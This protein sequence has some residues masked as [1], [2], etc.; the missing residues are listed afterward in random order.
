[1]GL[2][3]YAVFTANKSCAMIFL[4]TYKRTFMRNLNNVETFILVVETNSFTRAAKVRGISRAAASKQVRQLEDELGVALLMRSTREIVVTAEGQIVYEECRRIMENVT[5]VEAIL[6]GLKDEPSGLLSV[7]SGP[8]FANKYIIPYLAEFIEHYPK[9]HL[10]LD[11]RHLM[12]NMMEEKVDV[13]VGVYG[14]APP[15]AIQRS[16]IQTRR[17]MCASPTYLKKIGRPKKPADLLKH[18]LIIHPVHPNDSSIILK[19]G[20]QLNHM[21][22]VT[23]NDQLAIK[24][25]ALN[26]MGVAYIQRHVVEQEL[27]DGSLV[28]V[29]QDY[30]EKKDSISI[31]LYYLQRRHLHSKIRV[32]IDFVINNIERRG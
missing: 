27:Q 18:S 2:Y 32:F 17:I 8:V 22:T 30:M 25:C 20:K 24:R 26:D 11:L 29:L 7:V 1:M 10:K 28:E 31:F 14:T 16:V 3:A 13:V 23:I 9:I 21:P 5:E 6:S 4:R 19:G 15:D 12:P